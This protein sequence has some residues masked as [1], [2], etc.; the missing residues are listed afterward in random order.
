M[1]VH[2]TGLARQ[3]A[4]LP[5]VVSVLSEMYVLRPILTEE[6]ATEQRLTGERGA[7]CGAIERLEAAIQQAR[8]ADA[9]RQRREQWLALLEATQPVFHR[10]GLSR[11]VAAAKLA[12][13]EGLVNELLRDHDA[14]FQVRADENLTFTA[15]FHDGTEQPASRLSGGQKVV[16]AIAF[17][18]AVLLTFTGDVGFLCLDEP[19]EFLDEHNKKAID[20]ALAKLRQLSQARGLQCFVITHERSLLRLFD[21]A[22]QLG[23]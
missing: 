7:L 1:L 4:E 23:A 14:P 2:L 10:D 18:V 17:R 20:A 12:E 9:M 15:I 5:A 8:Q 16:L 6:A 22:F 21:A 3:L 11:L 19:T 13:V